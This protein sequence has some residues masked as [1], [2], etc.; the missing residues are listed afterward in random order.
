[1]PLAAKKLIGS[2]RMP[3]LYRHYDKDNNLLYVGVTDSI[4]RRQKDHKSRAHW[5]DKITSVT[6]EDYATRVEAL[7]AERLAIINEKPLANIQGLSNP[8]IEKIKDSVLANNLVDRLGGYVTDDELRVVI[9]LDAEKV[10]GIPA[11]CEITGVGSSYIYEVLRGQRQPSAMVA[12]KVGY[13]RV[14]LFEPVNITKK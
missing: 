14:I 5:Y 7:E 13:R 9:A 3:K 1:V 6:T 10:G 8:V 12:N 4:E 2:A 11:W